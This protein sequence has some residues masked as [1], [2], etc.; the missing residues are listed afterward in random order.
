LVGK[1][2]VFERAVA[3]GATTGR[4]GALSWIDEDADS[5]RHFFL[6]DE[7]VEDD[8]RPVIAIGSGVSFAILKDHHAGGLARIV[9]RGHVNPVVAHRAL[10]DLAC[11]GPR[12]DES[13]P[14]HT[15]LR[16]RVGPEPIIIR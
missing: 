14:G 9:L 13:A 16:H 1:R 5:Y 4:V 8:R 15:V 12:P 2:V 11:P 6:V 3:G 10:E 7:I